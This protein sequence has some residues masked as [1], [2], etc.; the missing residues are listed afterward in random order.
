M[1]AA[2]AIAEDQP[3]YRRV[4]RRANRSSLEFPSG[5]SLTRFSHGS[6]PDFG[7]SQLSIIRVILPLDA[8][9][10]SLSRLVRALTS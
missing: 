7:S 4:S 10:R 1:I 3:L 5:A 8:F 6:L 2:M 9:H